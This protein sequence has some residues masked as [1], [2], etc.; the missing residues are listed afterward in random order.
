MITIN[1]YRGLSGVRHCIP[2][3]SSPWTSVATL[4]D[5]DLLSRFKIS[6]PQTVEITAG[7]S[8]N[9]EPISE[10]KSLPITLNKGWSIC[11][12]PKIKTWGPEVLY[13]QNLLEG[14]PS[15]FQAGEFIWGP[16]SSNLWRLFLSNV[17]LSPLRRKKKSNG[18]PQ[19]QIFLP[20]QAALGRL[21][22]KAS[23]GSWLE[24]P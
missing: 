6:E 16:S 23:L 7:H 17:S 12:K 18:N 10:A 14:F 1:S 15:S 3:T 5:G 4:R 11:V 24:G 2:C 22:S 13:Y 21:P 8:L 20:N 9:P 19:V